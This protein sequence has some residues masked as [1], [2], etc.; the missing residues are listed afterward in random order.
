MPETTTTET[1]EPSTHPAGDTEPAELVVRYR[2]ADG[3]L[4]E[5]KTYPHRNEVKKAQ[6]RWRWCGSLRR[7]VL[8]RTR[9]RVL[10]SA[11]VEEY[12][13]GLRAAGVPNVRVD[14]QEPRPGDVLDVDQAG[15]VV[16]ALEGRALD[17]AGQ[18]DGAT[19]WLDRMKPITARHFVRWLPTSY[20][21][22]TGILDA[23]RS[24]SG[25]EL[26][27]P[28]PRKLGHPAARRVLEDL[29]GIDF[30]AEDEDGTIS[31]RCDDGTAPEILGERAAKRA[32]A[33]RARREHERAFRHLDARA[34]MRVGREAA[35]RGEVTKGRFNTAYRRLHP[36]FERAAWRQRA[37]VLTHQGRRI[38]ATVRGP[39]GVEFSVSLPAEADE[40]AVIAAL[41][42]RI[43]MAAR[44]AGTRQPTARTEPTP[45][46]ARGPKVDV[47]AL[48]KEGAIGTTATT[49]SAASEEISAV[50]REIEQVASRF[51]GTLEHEAA[52]ATTEPEDEKDTSATEEEHLADEPV[53]TK[54]LA[55]HRARRTAP[56]TSEAL[57]PLAASEPPPTAGE[58]QASLTADEDQAPPR[59]AGPHRPVPTRRAATVSGADPP[60]ARRASGSC[61][62]GLGIFHHAR[63]P[64]HA[65][66]QGDGQARRGRARPSPGGYVWTGLRNRG[67][68]PRH[69]RRP[70][71][72]PEATPSIATA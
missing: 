15:E 62:R 26:A 63:A 33:Q 56:G 58:D 45:R 34:L 21:N 47:E 46:A 22:A 1:V 12:A 72:A 54:E 3:I 14:Y 60:R 8:P 25:V 36:G 6:P 38:E 5:G 10:S 68:P 28:L 55:E 50:M 49:A 66:Q 35:S 71:A 32:A 17:R 19:A 27:Q 41:L 65:R 67:P 7:W 61:L 70:P 59:G 69:R 2:Y 64:P 31:P 53:D 43:E 9:E 51:I 40:R 30:D 13:E 39:K 24:R 52:E 16:E 44:A 11:Q 18:L 57:L 42:R 48:S 23:Y 20:R 4:I 37:L 29:F